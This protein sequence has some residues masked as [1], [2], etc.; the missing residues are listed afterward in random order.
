MSKKYYKLDDAYVYTKGDTIW[1]GLGI[2]GPY[3]ECLG[4]LDTK[5]NLFKKNTSDESFDCC[6]DIC[7][8][9]DK[10]EE[11]VDTCT[12]L[13]NPNKRIPVFNSVSPY[14]ECLKISKDN[15]LECCVDK[16][17]NAPFPQFNC[18]IFCDKLKAKYNPKYVQKEKV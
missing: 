1:S 17:N 9:N 16:C 6:L 10:T 15:V 12:K 7:L 13:C 5:T 2:L 8:G 4:S 14:S 3:Q 11:R 18:K